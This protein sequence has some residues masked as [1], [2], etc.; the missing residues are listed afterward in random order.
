VR[1]F[2]L[3][4]VLFLMQ[5]SDLTQLLKQGAQLR[6]QLYGTSPDGRLLKLDY[7]NGTWLEGYYSP[8]TNKKQNQ[9]FGFLNP[10]DGILRIDKTQPFRPQLGK[11]IRVFE[12][13]GQIIE[14]RIAEFHL[15]RLSPEWALGCKATLRS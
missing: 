13:N 3:G 10:H 4:A 11:T 9:E 6:K 14:M 8:I 12:S 7:D 2:L 1:C 15:H 5:A